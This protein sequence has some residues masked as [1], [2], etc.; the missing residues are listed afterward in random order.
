MDD[1]QKLSRLVG[2]LNL[3]HRL[4]NRVLLRAQL[5]I[6]RNPAPTE[7][8]FCAEL[9]NLWGLE[10]NNTRSTVRHMVEAGV[11][12]V[13][14]FK[15]DS[16]GWRFLRIGPPPERTRRPRSIVTDCDTGTPGPPAG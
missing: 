3:H 11:I 13:E 8:V 5:L 12:D 7:R 16:G 6:L 2:L 14:A 1:T 15:G 4:P 10:L 9:A